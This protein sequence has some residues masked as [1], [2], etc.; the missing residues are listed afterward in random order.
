MDH[1][2][3][4]PETSSFNVKFV[5]CT[6]SSLKKLIYFI[7]PVCFLF[8]MQSEKSAIFQMGMRNRIATVLIYVSGLAISFLIFQSL[9]TLISKSDRHSLFP[10]T[11]KI[12]RL[13]PCVLF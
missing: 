10:E 7:K 4:N 13:C 12:Y 6:L 11:S 2:R 1:A 9:M 3:V 5:A 8:Q